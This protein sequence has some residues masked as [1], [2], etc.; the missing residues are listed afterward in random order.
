MGVVEVVLPS[1]SVCLHTSA[2][3]SRPHMPLPLASAWGSSAQHLRCQ[4]AQVTVWTSASSQRVRLRSCESA[5]AVAAAV[6]AMRRHRAVGAG[7]VGRRRAGAS[8]GVTHV[9]SW[10]PFLLPV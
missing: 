7:L 9:Q 1:S 5:E 2:H 4:S 3:A 8:L 10:V 6:A